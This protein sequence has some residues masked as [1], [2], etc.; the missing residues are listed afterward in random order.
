MRLIYVTY[1]D[2]RYLGNFR[3]NAWAVRVLGGAAKA[4]LFTRE[5]LTASAIYGPHRDVFDAP[6]GAGYWAWKPWAILRALDECQPG[7]VLF[8]QDCG[9]GLR[10]KLF[11]RP[12][13]L[14]AMAEE[15]GFLAGVRC[16]QYGANRRWNR[17]ACGALMGCEGARFADVPSLQATLSFWTDTPRARAFLEEWLHWCLNLEAIRD[18]RPDE[19]A[20]EVEDFVEHRHDQ[21]IITNL[22]ILRDAPVIDCLPETLG[23]EKSAAMLEMDRRARRGGGAAIL[24]RLL[25]AAGRWRRG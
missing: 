13:A 23:F 17:K 9:F 7:D 10:Y 3:G 15:R 21:A 14:M 25:A 1:A 20:L 11:L 18:A 4:L 12:R 5:D 19:R 6:R 16:P 8:Y 24:L 2:G 22:A